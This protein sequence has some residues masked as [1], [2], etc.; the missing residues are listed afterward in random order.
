MRKLLLSLLVFFVTLQA[1]ALSIHSVNVQDIL[2]GEETELRIIVENNLDKDAS[3]VSLSL[4]MQN[5]PF[6][7][8]G[9]SDLTLEEIEEGEKEDFVF[10]IRAASTAEPGDYLIPFSLSHKDSSKAKTGAIGLR[11]KGTVVLDLN[12]ETEIPIIMEK[13]K[14]SLKIINKGFSDAR[15]VS[16]KVIPIG[17]NI[18]SEK[19]V[20]I[21]DIRANDF[22]VA[23]F[24]VI[25]SSISP[26][27]LVTLEYLDFSNT[28]NIKTIEESLRVYDPEEAIKAGLVEKNKFPI[29]VILA[30]IL[31]RVIRKR[32]KIKKKMNSLQ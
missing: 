3:E 24:D 14:L 12:I 10:R 20:F 18:L 5:L 17:F 7:I 6:S 23:T 21:G 26:K 8:I 2:P 31:L 1:S 15:Y 25:Y 13:D 28:K 22:E 32:N 4:Q 30:F 19:N 29:Y 16:I 11:I 27:F 9:S